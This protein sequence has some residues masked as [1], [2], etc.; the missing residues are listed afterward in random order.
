MRIPLFVGIVALTVASGVQ[1]QDPPKQCTD[2][3]LGIIEGPDPVTG[4]CR[5]ETAHVRTRIEPPAH[6]ARD[7]RTGRLV[8]V[9]AAPVAADHDIAL[10]EWAADGSARTLYLTSTL[11]DDLDPR[12]AL[13]PAGGLHVVWWSRGERDEIVYAQRDP[14]TDGWYPDRVVA[15]GGRSPALAVDRG[16]AWFAFVRDVLGGSEI[17]LVEPGVAGA[18]VTSVAVR[19]A[20]RGVTELYLTIRDGRPSLGWIESDGRVVHAERWGTMWV[21]H[22]AR[23]VLR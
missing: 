11:A 19:T 7:P 5:F 16:A 1:G 17:V 23:G 14:R 22:G 8:R 3:V 9:S 4:R 10:T 18:A 2:P 12:L 6:Q 21:R 13:D 15:I 20:D